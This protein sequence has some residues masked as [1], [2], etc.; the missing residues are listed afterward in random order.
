M[1]RKRFKVTLETYRSDWPDWDG[2]F[3]ELIRIVWART[4]DNAWTQARRKFVGRILDG[5]EENRREWIDRIISVRKVPQ[6]SAA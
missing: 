2:P 5:N 6:P 4:E 3:D 1:A